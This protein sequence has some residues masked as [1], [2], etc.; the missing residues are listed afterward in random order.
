MA[1][2]GSTTEG[3]G[4]SQLV[5]KLGHRDEGVRERALKSI[6]F[7]LANGLVSYEQLWHISEGNN[8]NEIFAMLLEWFNFPVVPMQ[9]EV[10]DLLHSI[11]ARSGKAA[12]LLVQAGGINF[13]QALK[14]DAPMALLPSIQAILNMLLL[15]AP[16][17]LPAPTISA[18]YFAASEGASWSDAPSAL[19]LHSSVHSQGRGSVSFLSRTTAA[20]VALS[21][22]AS[23]LSLAAVH[24]Q[25]HRQPLRPDLQENRRL[26]QL[27]QEDICWQVPL[28]RLCNE[29]TQVLFALDVKLKM[30]DPCAITS[31][32]EAL[33]HILVNEYPPEVLLQKPE[34][35]RN[36]LALIQ[37]TDHADIDTHALS[38]MHQWVR[39][40]KASMRQQLLPEMRR[41]KPLHARFPS[42]SE[43]L[44]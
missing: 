39:A 36:L 15:S 3:G 18:P 12:T 4:V 34:I 31:A 37:T 41:P 42:T 5:E 23:M 35:F 1:R 26:H 16:P 30:T 27:L 8:D 40:L 10:L 38:L 22:N 14:S 17:P 6:L 43:P 13:M 2:R 7:K 33:T 28:V 19:S 21:G 44:M 24:M 9:A 32:L 11:C 29:D 25:Q 20:A